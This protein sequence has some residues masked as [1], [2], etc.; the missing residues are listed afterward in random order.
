VV[1]VVKTRLAVVTQALPDGVKLTPI[2]DRTGLVKKAVETAE[3]ASIEVSILVVIILLL[4]LGELR[5]ALVVISALPLAML[6]AFIFM[7]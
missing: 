2:Y 6:I 4:F 3:R 7:D 5:S 1:D